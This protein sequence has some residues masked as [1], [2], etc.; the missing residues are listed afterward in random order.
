[1]GEQI[2]TGTRRKPAVLG[3]FIQDFQAHV[4]SLGYTPGS[5]RGMLKVVG[6]LGRWL[7][8][9]HLQVADFS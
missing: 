8:D 4:L 7:A 3:P 2:M 1:M 5:T 6:Q 9:Q